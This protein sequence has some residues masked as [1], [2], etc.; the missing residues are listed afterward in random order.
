MASLLSERMESLMH[1][2]LSLPHKMVGFSRSLLWRKALRFSAIQFTLHFDVV[3]VGIGS[4]AVDYK[5]SAV[6]KN[7]STPTL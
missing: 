5:P 7:C 1:V 6:L 2:T 4:M 3:R